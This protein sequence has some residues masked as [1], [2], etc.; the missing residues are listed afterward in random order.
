[1]RVS[2]GLSHDVKGCGETSTRHDSSVTPR[3]RRTAST[4][5]RWASGG[6]VSGGTGGRPAAPAAGGAGPPRGRGGE[7]AEPL[8]ERV[9]DLADARA[10]E[11]EVVVGEH[12]VVG[13]RDVA[14]ARRVLAR[15]LD[16]APQRGREGGEVARGARRLPRRLA[17]GGRE[18]DLAGELLRDAARAVPVAAGEAH[19]VAVEVAQ[20]AVA[21]VELVEPGADLV[22]GR[23]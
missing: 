23:S 4:A 9:E 8:G 6:T 22:G 10:R 15:E 19:D 17:V 16:V 12:R 5:A 7:R 18:R 11:A 1:M 20:G 13:M 2:S 3:R 14:E 21:C